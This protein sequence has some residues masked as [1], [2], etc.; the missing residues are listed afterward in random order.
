MS[1]SRA[2][3]NWTFEGWNGSSWVTLDTRINQSSWGDNEIRYYKISSPSAYAKYR[4]NITA[5][6]GDG[7]YLCV[8]TLG[9]Y[10]Q[11]NVIGIGGDYSG[12]Y[13]NWTPSG[14]SVTAGAGNDSM[15][16][17]PTLYGTDARNGG[18][19]RGNYATLNPLAI[20]AAS[21]TISVANGNLDT[22]DAGTTYG[23]V[24][25][26]M[27]VS[28][29]KWYWE[30][31]VTS[32]SNSTCEIGIKKN[33]AASMVDSNGV[34][35]T[36]DSY[37]YVSSGSKRNNTSTTAYGSSWTTNN[38]IGVAL[39]LDAGTLVFYRDGATQGTAFSGLSGEYFPAFGDYSNAGQFNYACNFGQ[40]PFANTAPSGF[41][42][43]C[44]TN[45]PDPDI[46][47]G[48]A[49]FNTIV[50]NGN[51]TS[52]A[53]TGLGFQPDLVWAKS[54]DANSGQNW[55]DS[56]RG[57]TKNLQTNNSGSPS[58]SKGETTANTVISF[59][60]DGFT[61]GDGL[62]LDI[63]KGGEVIIGR[64]WKASNSTTNIAVGSIDG[65]NPT[66]AST[67][68]A[69]PTAG[70]SIVTYTGI[71]ANATVAHG[72]SPSGFTNVPQMVITKR[73]NT[74]GYDWTMYHAGLP[75][76]DYAI[77]LNLL[78]GQ[79][80]E[81]TAWNSTAPTSQYFNIGIRSGTGSA[82][83]FVAYVFAPIAGYSAF[84]SYRGAPSKTFVY[85]G[86]RPA[87]VILKKAT[88]TSTSYGWPTVDN[89]RP[90]TV[91][92]K[93]GYNPTLE[94]WVDQSV[95]EATSSSYGIDLLSNGFCINVGGNTNINDAGKT[96]IYAAFAE[97]PF[98]YS[99]AR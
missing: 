65:T 10:E 32:Q 8:A 79:A 44:T 70:F 9:L 25:A 19:V 77:Y 48:S 96:F 35:G 91:V 30:V 13:N 4:I 49:H 95:G 16:D 76:A 57:A 67:V 97:N 51:G 14:F 52:Q 6:N 23:Y 92:G 45:L 89:L 43:L 74:D 50:W 40:R 61:V 2:P 63:N 88:E 81:P 75:S 5:N 11:A 86:F 31:F 55:V 83:N 26:T 54:T 12:N 69:N 27:A 53:I 99:L 82:G 58:T 34:A 22:S 28:S 42:C 64:C 59:D 33:T 78:D 3:K 60:S 90:P 36:S 21:G 73:I 72:L 87:L 85:T 7:T 20:K 24:P 17:V 46:A 80:N 29:G 41:K 38:V 93:T 1:A 39:D 18:E 68:S 98:K 71:N 66:I 37:S 94:M 47:D 84:G 15:V 56:V 62:G